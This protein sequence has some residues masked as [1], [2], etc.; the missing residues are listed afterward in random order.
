M[1]KDVSII[2]NCRNGSKYLDDCLSSIKNQK[3][4]NWELYFFDNCSTDNSYELYKKY[5]DKDFVT[6]NLIKF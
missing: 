5:K 2:V 1:S 3:F 6:L 4:K